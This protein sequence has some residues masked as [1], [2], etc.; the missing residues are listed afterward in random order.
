MERSHQSVFGVVSFTLLSCSTDHVE[1]L[2]VI[3]ILQSPILLCSFTSHIASSMGFRYTLYSS[4]MG[5]TLPAIVPHKA[6]RVSRAESRTITE[7]EG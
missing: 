1:P 3:S 4:Q 6:A 5:C 2:S 7:Q